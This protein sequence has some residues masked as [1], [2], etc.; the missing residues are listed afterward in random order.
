VA[1][2][3]KKSSSP[4]AKGKGGGGKSAVVAPTTAGVGIGK[5]G[6]RLP[7]LDASAYANFNEP[8]G[9]GNARFFNIYEFL[10]GADKKEPRRKFYPI[11][12][13]APFWSLMGLDVYVERW[14]QADE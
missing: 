14:Q 11:E 2:L 7:P 12:R 13:V 9:V 8:I 5:S 3:T 1:A 6:A 4:P 10:A